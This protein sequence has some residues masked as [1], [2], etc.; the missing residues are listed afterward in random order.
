M[1]VPRSRIWRSAR[2]AAPPRRV[3]GDTRPAAPERESEASAAAVTGEV[4]PGPAFDKR[5]IREVPLPT[6]P[7][8][9]QLAVEESARGALRTLVLEGE[10]SLGSVPILEAAIARVFAQPLSA[11]VLD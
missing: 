7:D 3:T 1:R 8:Q 2:E 11:L 4:S 9:A 10:L 5:I 6:K